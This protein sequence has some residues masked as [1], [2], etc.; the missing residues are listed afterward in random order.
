MSKL[1]CLCTRQNTVKFPMARPP[2][3]AISYHQEDTTVS[4]R[5]SRENERIFHNEN[6]YC[7]SYNSRKISLG[8][9]VVPLLLIQVSYPDTTELDCGYIH[10]ADL[11]AAA[12]SCE[13]NC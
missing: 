9:Q 4:K 3:E 2:P 13:L 5:M 7:M 12:D 8:I 10:E 6:V 11:A 1:C